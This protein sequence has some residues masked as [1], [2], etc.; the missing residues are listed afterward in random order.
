LA[1]AVFLSTEPRRW[2]ALA[3]AIFVANIVAQFQKRSALPVST[4][5][6]L[7]NAAEPLLAATVLV[8]VSGVRAAAAR[9]ADRRWVAGLVA[10]AGG[11]NAV[12]ALAGAV[13]V[14]VAFGVKFD[15]AWLT[16]WL[17]DG[18]GMLA[19]APVLLG[20]SNSSLRRQVKLPD[21]VLM[22]AAPAAALWVFWVPYAAAPSPLQHRRFGLV[23]PARAAIWS[24]VAPR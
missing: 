9:V 10:A 3:G 5:L 13:V 15:T 21:I 20:L 7:V 11:A 6:A 17:A 19:F 1:L 22:A 16:W 23:M 18:L 8:R 4:A 2:P 14:T 12:T 24:T